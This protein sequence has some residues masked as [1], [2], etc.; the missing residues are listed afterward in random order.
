LILDPFRKAPAWGLFFAYDRLK[1]MLI[2][3]QNSFK[4]NS[5]KGVFESRSEQEE[6][7]HAKRIEEDSA[8]FLASGARR[9]I[10]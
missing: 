5:I 3:F 9:G 6:F 4:M 2:P 8:L 10:G 1:R 7:E